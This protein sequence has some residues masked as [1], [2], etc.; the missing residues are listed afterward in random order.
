MS[1][2]NP[3]VQYKDIL[4]KYLTPYSIFKLGEAW[5]E[6][7][8]KYHNEDHLVQILKDL[9]KS[10]L[11]VLPIHWEALVLAAF[12][13]DAVY[14]PGAQD[15]EAK[16]I[17]AFLSSFQGKNASMVK[18]IKEMI[19][20]TQFRSIPREPLIK[21]F[22]EA[23]NAGFQGSFE[24]FLEIEK[25]IRV[26]FGHISLHTYK[27]GRIKFLKSCLGLMGPKADDNCNKL[28]QY[29]EKITKF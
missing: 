7:R 22:W 21:L 10:K 11:K 20:S 18:A 23:D 1:N 19:K 12:F 14:I 25:K 28:I 6:P 5:N 27:K 26:E 9:E 8:R 13:H 29:I 4:E 15:N 3:F 17:K 24:N 16:S 2:L